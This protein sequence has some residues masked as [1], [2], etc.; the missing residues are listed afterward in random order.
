VL[1]VDLNARSCDLDVDRSLVGALAW[2]RRLEAD[3]VVGV[4]LSEDLRHFL[5]RGVRVRYGSSARQVWQ[6]VERP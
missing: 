3:D 1:R 6:N 4:G 5:F 2:R